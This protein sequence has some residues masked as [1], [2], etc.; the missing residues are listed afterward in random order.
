VKRTETTVRRSGRAVFALVTGGGTGGHVQP[1]L[2]IAEALVE[3]GHDRASIHF[4]GGRRGMEGTLVPENGFGITRLPGRG[5]ER[6]LSMRNVRSSFEIAAALAMAL[7]LV[8]SRRPSVVITVGGYAGFPAAFAAAA[9]GIPLVVV[10]YDAVP[11]AANRLLARR[12]AANAVAFPSTQLP[13]AVVTGPPVRSDVLSVDRSEAGRAAARAELG[14][15][16]ERRLV[17]VAGGSLGARSINE[18]TLAW[19]ERWA[20]RS[21]VCVYH[22]AGDRDLEVVAARARQAKVGEGLLEYRLVGF[23]RRMPLLLSACD[24]FVGRAGASTVAELCA[25]GVPSVLV[26][27]PNAPADHQTRNAEALVRA[28]A[29]ILVPDSACSGE[30]LATIVSGLLEEPGRLRAM[31]EAARGLG[32]RDAAS[33]IASVAESVAKTR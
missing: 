33:R 9:L 19:C 10:T 8:A 12:A 5:F 17:L 28:G 23:E 6:R 25:I 29:S 4:V 1:A 26:P 20:D 21:D 30:Q 7:R 18:A 13:R 31:E 3:A 16:Q 11:G 14:I 32:H 22:V 15:E 27:L 2:A 24:L